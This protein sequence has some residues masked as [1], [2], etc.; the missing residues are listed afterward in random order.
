MRNTHS[1]IHLQKQT[2]LHAQRQDFKT[3]HVR[4]PSLK[5]AVVGDS[6]RF[7][8]QLARLGAVGPVGQLGGVEGGAL[9]AGG[10][11][12]VG[13]RVGGMGQAGARLARVVVKLHQAEDQVGRHQL[14][15]VRR[16]GYHVSGGRG[17]QGGEKQ[18]IKMR[19]NQ[20]ENQSR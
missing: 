17:G 3:L 19:A 9:L 12:G 18:P 1:Y 16:V 10:V 6:L 8:P 2:N 7:V 14:E 5:V 11:G 4:R 13:G 20:D 15:R